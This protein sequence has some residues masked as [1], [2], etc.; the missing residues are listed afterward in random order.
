MTSRTH[1]RFNAPAMGLPIG[2]LMAVALIGGPLG[3]CATDKSQIK[4]FFPPN[5]GNRAVNQMANMQADLGARADATLHPV[6]FDGTRLNSLGEQKLAALI[7]QDPD[8][9]VNVYLDMPEN[10]LAEA[11]RDVVKSYL[12]DRGVTATHAKVQI[13]PNPDTLTPAAIGVARLSKTETGQAGGVAAVEQ[14]GMG[15]SGR[16]GGTK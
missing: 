10:E 9:D 2:L 1:R 12:M 13:G 16:S 7:G 3:G 15:L 14:A 4:D 5:D 11:R 6:H 8:A